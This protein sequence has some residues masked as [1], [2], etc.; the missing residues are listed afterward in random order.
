[1][2]LVFAASLVASVAAF[3]PASVSKTSMV[4]KAYETELGVV[5]PTGTHKPVLS[6]RRDDCC[7]PGR[8]KNSHPTTFSFISYIDLLSV[9]GYFDPLGLA[10]NIDKE[11]FDHW[12][13]SEVKHGRVCMLAV[14]GYIVPEFYRFPGEIAPGLKFADVPHGIAAINAIPALGWAQIFFAIGATDYYGFLGDFEFGKATGMDAATLETRK[15]NELSNGRLAMLATLELLRHD[16]QNMM[17]PGFD[18]YDNLIV[19][20][21]GME[22]EL[23]GNWLIISLSSFCCNLSKQN[24][25]ASPS[26]TDSKRGQAL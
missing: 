9:S 5:A 2:K 24:R 25:P 17:Q 1:M 7:G 18:G 4:L 3:A 21:A 6:N 11:T 10:A 26:S 23:R 12:R 13:A 14:I 22:I 16:S 15:M 8:G 20:R 19:S